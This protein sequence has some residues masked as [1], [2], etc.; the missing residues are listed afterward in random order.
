MTALKKDDDVVQIAIVLN[1][2]INKDLFPLSDAHFPYYC[3]DKKTKILPFINCGDELIG[4]YKPEFA[5]KYKYLI[6]YWI[7]TLDLPRLNSAKI[8]KIKTPTSSYFVVAVN[9]CK[10]INIEK[11][12]GRINSTLDVP[13]SSK[14]VIGCYTDYDYAL[15]AKTIFDKKYRG[16]K[17]KVSGEMVFLSYSVDNTQHSV[18]IKDQK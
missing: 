6:N 13:Y 9:T 1:Y 7:T 17:I 12:L 15:I 2:D 18:G 10:R 8:M 11:F 4:A 16:R 14:C 5:L 3:K